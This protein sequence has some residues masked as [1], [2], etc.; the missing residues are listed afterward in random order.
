M[1]VRHMRQILAIHRHGS[2]MK[3][4]A[5]L[6]VA[7]P[8][9]SKSIARLEDEL[10]LKLFDRTGSGAK[11][12]PM[13]ALVAERAD[14]IVVEA[15]RL[16]RDVALVGVGEL[17]QARIGVGAG[18]REIFLPAFAVDIATRYRSLRLHL[19][20]ESRD[21]LLLRLERGDCD[22]VFAVDGPDMQRPDLVRSE[23]FRDHTAIVA[24]PQHPLAG[25]RH[26]PIETF[27]Q[28]PSA[29]VTA[30]TGFALPELLGLDEAA[31]RAASFFICNDYEASKRLAL[32]G[33]ATTMMPAHTV[34]RELKSGALVE[35]D[36]DWRLD[37]TIVALM[38]RAASHAPILREIAERA[39]LIGQSLVPAGK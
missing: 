6:G 15:E 37:L 21:L 17:G 5:D 9:L 33:L 29:T 10:G 24:A 18:L 20:V 34:Q 2:F 27:V 31:S 30:S 38:T 16:E 19:Q 25:R 28:F 32:A 1:D 3:A 26:I 4:A 39:R 22:L 12:T 7:Q 23:I 8:T 13:G 11:L 35:L 14:R 36:L